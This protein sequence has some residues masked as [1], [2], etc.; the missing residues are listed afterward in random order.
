MLLQPNK[1]TM[2]KLREVL[3]DL[4]KH[5]DSSAA[6]IIDVSKTICC[7]L[8]LSRLPYRISGLL[9][10]MIGWEWSISK[11]TIYEKCTGGKGETKVVFNRAWGYNPIVPTLA[12]LK[13]VC[14][15]RGRERLTTTVKVVTWSEACPICSWSVSLTKSFLWQLSLCAENVQWAC[16]QYINTM[17]AQQ[18]MCGH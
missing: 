4:Y 1:K 12:S 17:A 9:V 14:N 6:S 10:A 13:I 11:V 5:L 3:Y 8:V 2:K 7:Y 15:P 18:R 16:P